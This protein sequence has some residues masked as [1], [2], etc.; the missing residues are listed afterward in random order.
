MSTY[1]I[2]E[3]FEMNLK[4]RKELSLELGGVYLA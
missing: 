4:P 2:E 3:H 1:K